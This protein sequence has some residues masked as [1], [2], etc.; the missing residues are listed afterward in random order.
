MCRA[1]VPC[2]VVH[3][4]EGGRDEAWRMVCVDPALVHFLFAAHSPSFSSVRPL[5]METRV[6]LNTCSNATMPRGSACRRG[7]W[8]TEEKRL[9][10]C[11]SAASRLRLQTLHRRKQKYIRRST[12]ARTRK[13][14]AQAQNC[15]RRYVSPVEGGRVWGAWRTWVEKEAPALRLHQQ[16]VCARV[17]VARSVKSAAERGGKRFTKER[18]KKPLCS[19]SSRA[20]ILGRGRLSPRPKI[21][22]LQ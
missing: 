22:T 19:P 6:A 7:R 8:R 18:K 14:D 17:Q 15:I 4:R 9:G 5:C 16:V 3:A 12:W 20:P 2:D 13:S 21:E 10:L 11:E 1:D